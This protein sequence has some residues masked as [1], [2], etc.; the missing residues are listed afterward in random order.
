LK[1]TVKRLPKIRVWLW[2]VCIAI[3]TAV[4]YKTGLDIRPVHTDEAVNAVITSERLA[5]Q[6][7]HYDP[8]DRHGPSLS[9]LESKVFEFYSVNRLGD[10]NAAELRI[11][12]VLTAAASIV[13]L[14]LL[15]EALPG[16]LLT[17]ALIFALGAP[18]VFYGRYAL[19]EPVLIF[20]TLLLIAS[21]SR[22][23][24]TGNLKWA[25]IAGL[26]TG[27]ALCTKEASLITLITLGLSI[28][29][30]SK[31]KSS[32]A[33]LIETR[34]PLINQSRVRFALTLILVV[35]VGLVL[36]A[37]SSFG[38]NPSGFYDFFRS[39]PLLLKRAA[40][41]GHEKPWYTYV[42]WLLKPTELSFPF[43]G[44]ITLGFATLGAI[45]SFFTPHN[46]FLIRTLVVYGLFIFLIYSFTPYKTPWLMLEFL[47]PAVLVAGYGMASVWNLSKG[48]LNPVLQRAITLIVI[49]L[50]VRQTDRLCFRYTSESQNPFSYSSTSPDL[51]RLP[52]RLNHVAATATANKPFIVAV[53]SKDYWPLPWTLRS[54]NH[55]GYFDQLPETLEVSAVISSL[56]YAPTVA[57]QLGKNWVQEFVGL[58]QDVLIVLF[59]PESSHSG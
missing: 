11:S 54:F 21:L 31:F 1:S 19:H 45:R 20:S 29:V 2:L 14:G 10:M 33:E 28:F 53:V 26:S 5:G 47:M 59:T 8:N 17:S 30:C 24:T 48:N 41:S 32:R 49:F 4:F 50:L 37:Y 51:E 40:G 58:R 12:S 52:L 7:Y 43:F 57:K 22:L 23:W 34:S 3:A 42:V 56:E 38:K 15:P 55:V 9:W 27:L 16:A 25:L 13:V 46:T 6:A 35:S 44:W 39:I 18:F 36:L